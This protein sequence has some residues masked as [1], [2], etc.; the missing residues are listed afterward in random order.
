MGN[1]AEA[2]RQMKKYNQE[3]VREAV[4]SLDIRLCPDGPDSF[5]LDTIRFS[6]DGRKRYLYDRGRHKLLYEVGPLT[7][8]TVRKHL[9]PIYRDIRNLAC[10]FNLEWTKPICYSE[11]LKVEALRKEFELSLDK[12]EV[13]LVFAGIS[14]PIILWFFNVNLFHNALLTLLSWYF[15][16]E[17]IEELR[18]PR[19]NRYRERARKFFE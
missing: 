8:Q 10:Y 6:F 4:K 19:F 12:K 5:V 7:R 15:I 18:T 9:S 17:K 1:K 11:Y 2:V 3:K 14:L 16:G 13:L